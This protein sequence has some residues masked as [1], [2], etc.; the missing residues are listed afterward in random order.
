MSATPLARMDRARFIA[1]FGG[2][3][4][5]SP[6]VAEAA[7][8]RG[9]F[10]DRA[11]LHRAMEKVVAE[12]SPARQLALIRAHPELGTRVALTTASRREQRGAGLDAGAPTERARL[13]ELSAT[14]SAR[15][16]FPFILAVK[17]KGR[18][19]I[20]AA[21]TA[22]LAHSV[23]EEH[24]TALAEIGRIAY[25]RLVDLVPEDQPAVARSRA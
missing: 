15:F 22:R 21:L 11:A 7:W 18:A 23:A 4:E 13:L 2:V 14:Y 8:A 10:A 6:W 20:I 5:H 25:F 12:A 17:G 24:A 19:E 9:P 1:T 16:G 3:Y